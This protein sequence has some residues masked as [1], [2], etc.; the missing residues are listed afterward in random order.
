MQLS[1]TQFREI[2]ATLRSDQPAG[3]EQRQTPRV[4]V[5]AQ[6]DMVTIGARGESGE[7]TKIRLVDLSAGGISFLY[8]D[9][10]AAGQSMEVRLPSSNGCLA[11]HAEVRHCRRIHDELFSVGAQYTRIVDPTGITVTAGRAR[12]R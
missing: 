3:S 6:V 11:I 5:R 9:R 12:R 7:L 1:A 10:L 8:R 2:L 4:G